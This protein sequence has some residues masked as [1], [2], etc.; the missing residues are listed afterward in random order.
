LVPAS[1]ASVLPGTG[2]DSSHFRPGLVPPITRETN[3]PVFLMIARVLW[4][5]GVREFV[6]AAEL[7]RREIPDARFW[8]LGPLDEGNPSCVPEEYVQEHVASG[9]IRYF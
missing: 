7:C 9:C 6:E 8:L 1:K 5:K 3:G 2:V 4:D